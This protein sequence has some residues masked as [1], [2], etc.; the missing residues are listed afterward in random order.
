MRF[1]IQTL[2]NIVPRNPVAAAA[3]GDMLGVIFFSLA[4]GVALA[5]L[6][7]ARSAIVK[8]VLQVVGEAM[9]VVIDIAMRLAP[10]GVFALVFTVTARFGLDV[11]AR[12]G[13]YVLTVLL[14]LAIFEFGIYG[15]LVRIFARLNPLDFFRRSWPI[16]VTAFSTSSSNATLPT[17]LREG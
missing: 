6:P 12:L 17:T 7:A 2:V 11:M 16:I 1:G 8:D 4:F 13:W 14:G 5:L 10:V 3:Q 15:A 9:A